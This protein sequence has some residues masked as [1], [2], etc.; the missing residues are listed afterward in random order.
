MTD[1]EIVALYFDRSQ[2]A[3]RETDHKYGRYCYTIAYRVLGD[4]EDSDE[5]VNDTYLRT[6]KA[7]PP[8]HPR[9][10][11]A[12]LGKITRN[13]ALDR[14]ERNHAARRGAESGQ[15]PLALEELQE[16]VS[17][18]DSTE[19]VVD[20]LVLAQILNRFL[21]E[22]PEQTRKLFVGRYWYFDSTKEL[23]WKY[24]MS[25]AN[26]KTSL[27][28]ARGRLRETLQKEGIAV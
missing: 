8:K 25:E 2:E 19:A 24:G 18:G 12:F 26:V 5:C 16:C 28:R 3:I 7:I 23:A 14:W 9:L 22:L 20:R 10:L 1:E 4:H 21:E 11:S 17:G 13:L 6:W 27:F 15:L